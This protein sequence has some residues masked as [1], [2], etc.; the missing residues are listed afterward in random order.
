MIHV[1][2]F[3]IRKIPFL[4]GQWF[5]LLKNYT[6]CLIE[7]NAKMTPKVAIVFTQASDMLMH[8]RLILFQ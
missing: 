3:D 1:F 4:T 7:S 6:K 5:S 2:Y 8:V